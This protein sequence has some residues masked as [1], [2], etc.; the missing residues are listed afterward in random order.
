MACTILSVVLIGVL[1]FYGIKLTSTTLMLSSSA[2]L[3]VMLSGIIVYSAIIVLF[4]FITKKE[5]NKG[6][7]V[8]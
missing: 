3:G 1:S 5:F 2:F 6:V 7:N 8:D 4:Y